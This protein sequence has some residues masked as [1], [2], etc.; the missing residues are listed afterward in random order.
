MLEF[1][2]KQDPQVAEAVGLELG[3]QRDK[4]ELIASENFVSRAVMEAMG[5][6]LTNK[7]AEGY[8]GRRYYGGCEYVD[9][10]ENIARDRIKELFG[11]EHANVQPHSGAQANMAVYFTILKPGDTVLGMNLSHGGHLTHGSP[12]NFSGSLY[13]FVEYGVDEQS[14]LINYDDVRAKALEHKPKLIVAGASAYPR[15]I[16]FAK[17]RE[18]ADEVGAYFMVDMAHIAGLVAAGL[19][20]NPVPHAHFVTSTTHKTLRGPRGGLILC[21]EEFAKAIDKSVFPGVQGGPLMHVIA[22]KAVSFGEALQPEFKAY[23]QQ[24]V[25]NA[26]AFA[27]ALQAE[28]LTLVS[29]GT[30][31]HLVL[32]DVRNLGL[33]GKVAEHLLDEVNITTNKNTIPYDPE[34]PFV[35][36]GVRM[37]TPAVTS[38]GFDE[39]AMK[40][41]AAIIALTLK[42]PEDA[43]KHEE[44]RQR[45]SALCQRFPMYEGLT[46]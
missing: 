20:P 15:T 40:E 43:A 26:R 41:V 38:R 9:I 39:A 21:K 11:A 3:R 4:I 36:S 33:T 10:V 14:H 31:N 42:N 8:P 25:N 13:N 45:V 5:T 2:R 22:A 34:S 1:L 17:F 23:A 37:G 35:T 29:G 32:V 6:V 24:I 7:Y 44:A 16:D 46:V 18:I 12:V 28:G 19:H 27:E 30:D